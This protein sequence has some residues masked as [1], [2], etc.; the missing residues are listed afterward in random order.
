MELKNSNEY[1]GFNQK[2]TLILRM[3]PL[4]GK[5]LKV[6]L[7]WNENDP[8]RQIPMLFIKVTKWI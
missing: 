8:Q 1:N 2:T 5:F 4:S 6:R 7:F 3:I